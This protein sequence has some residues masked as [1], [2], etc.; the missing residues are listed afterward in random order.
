MTCAWGTW[1]GPCVAT[2]GARPG[3]ARVTE[4]PRAPGDSL[5]G[6]SAPGT[7]P[8]ASPS[9]GPCS[10]RSSSSCCFTTTA[11]TTSGG[12]LA[13]VAFAVASVT[14]RVDGQIAR[15]RGLVTDFGKIADP[16]ADKAL[17]GAAL[18]GLSLLGDCLVDH[19]RRAR[20]RDRRDPAAVLRHPARRDAGQPRRQGQDVAAGHRHRPARAAARRRAAL[21]AL[22]VMYAAVV[23]TVVTGRRLRRPRRA[24]APHQRARGA[25]AGAARQAAVT[26]PRRRR[27]RCTELL[28]ARGETLAV[29]ESLTGGL[30]G[31]RVTALPGSSATFRGGVVAYA[32]ELKASLLGVDAGAAGRRRRG[33]PRRR[34]G[35]GARACASGSGPP[36]A[37]RRPGV[38]G[39]DPQDGHPPG[40]STWR[41]P[42][43]AGARV[44][45]RARLAG[46]RARCVRREPSPPRSRC[47]E[48]RARRERIAMITALHSSHQAARPARPVDR[49]RLR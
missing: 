19:R 41:W 6:R 5:T 18:I 14:D 12:W 13:F 36:L 10:C 30:L 2:E 29:A 9:C 44:G 1:Y 40:R 11:A 42:G 48:P 27:R 25:Q 22:L 8:T 32:T 21:V 3:G 39:P 31:R 37:W 35:D 7:S 46:D 33:P 20:A 49:Y 47:R 45:R 38:A 16:I 28:L 17:I 26:P 4:P 43:R 24:A 23:V 15:R 34:G